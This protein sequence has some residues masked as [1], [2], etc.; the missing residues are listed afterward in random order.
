MHARLLMC[1]PAVA[2]A[3]SWAFTAIQLGVIIY[4]DQHNHPMQG[5]LDLP[6][7]TSRMH[8]VASPL[9]ASAICTLQPEYYA[10]WQTEALS[11]A[12]FAFSTSGSPANMVLKHESEASLLE[13]SKQ[14]D[15][16]LKEQDLD[17]LDSLVDANYTIH[18]DGITLKVPD[19]LRMLAWPSTSLH[20]WSALRSDSSNLP[21]SF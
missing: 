12:V 6:A 17:K 3:R 15:A 7:Q 4:S 13:A 18:A 2:A 10:S 21:W 20:S 8:A 9:T 1:C 11:T 14:Y 5:C 19:C 16:A